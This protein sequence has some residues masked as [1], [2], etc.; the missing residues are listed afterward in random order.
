MHADQILFLEDGRIVER[1]THEE[2]L[3]LG[4]RYRALYDLQ[5]R[6]D[7]D[8]PA[9]AGARL[10]ST[11]DDDDEKRRHAAAGRH[12][13]WS[14]RTAIEEEVFGKAYDP[15]IVRRIWSFVQP[16]RRQDLHLGRGGAGLHADAARRSR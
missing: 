11:A 9:T 15:R 4:G 5:L 16:Y 13:R 3:A 7:D 2:L 10:M 14:A 6:P 1:G 12:R 8:A